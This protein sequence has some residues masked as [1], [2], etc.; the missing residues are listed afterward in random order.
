MGEAIYINVTDNTCSFKVD[1]HTLLTKNNDL[2]IT[3]S[4]PNCRNLEM[5]LNRTFIEYSYI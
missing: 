1:P 4:N 2:L 3:L 5:N